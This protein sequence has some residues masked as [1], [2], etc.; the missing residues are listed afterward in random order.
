MTALIPAGKGTYALI[1][2][3]AQGQ[4]LQVGKL[5]AFDF[6]AGYYLYIG[7]AFG[8]GGLARRLGRHIALNQANASCHWHID[9]LRRRA[10]IVAVWLSRHQ[11][12]HEH[13]WA[14]LAGQLAGSSYP[15]PRFG[16]SDCRCRA[17]LFHFAQ[18]PAV[19]RFAALLDRAL[20]GNGPLQII[21]VAEDRRPLA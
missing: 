13:D 1:L 16:A 19:E 18:P 10:P 14:A 8:P 20:P 2:H 7:S 15:A 5:G 17:H 3:L 9:Y 11:T 6:P 4:S 21:Q 12:R